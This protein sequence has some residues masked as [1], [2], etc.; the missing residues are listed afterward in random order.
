MKIRSIYLINALREVIKYYPSLSL[1]VEPVTISEPYRPL[2]HYMT[3]LEEYKTNHPPGHDDNYK[4]ITNSHIDIS[5]GF[6]D[7][8]LGK[9]LRL[10]RERYQRPTPVVT[11]EYLWLLFKPGQDVYIH[12]PDKNT[13]T[14]G[15][16][17]ELKGGIFGSNDSPIPYKIHNWNVMS[18]SAYIQPF[19]QCTTIEIFDGEK[20]IASL[21]V[22]PKNFHSE[23]AKLESQLVE[24]G[25]K[26]WSMCK[27]AYMLC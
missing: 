12:D 1:P 20:D 6:L 14:A 2:V 27:L 13:W 22:L 15:V 8:T 5:L 17:A 3:E 7:H 25:K 10:E 18:R 26:Y 4:N 16:V 11:F 21:A 24:R 19:K 9:Q 23:D